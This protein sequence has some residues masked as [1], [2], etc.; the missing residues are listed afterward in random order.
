[1][2]G[3]RQSVDRIKIGQIIFSIQNLVQISEEKFSQP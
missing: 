1:M 3:N 2:S